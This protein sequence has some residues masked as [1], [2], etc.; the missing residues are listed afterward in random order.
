MKIEPLKIRLIY[1]FKLSLW[2]AIKIRIAGK[3]FSDAAQEFIKQ[4]LFKNAV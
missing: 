2:T 3:I 4:Q 1:D